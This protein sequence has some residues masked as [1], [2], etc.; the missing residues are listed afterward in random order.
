MSDT[1]RIS[2]LEG[3]IADL[4]RQLGEM[5]RQLSEAELDQW[6]GR[7]DDLEVQVHL[8]TLDV[9]DRL[10]PLIED[11][12]N[13]WLDAREQLSGSTETASDV[14]TTLRKGLEQA[15]GEIR[16]AVLEAR[17]TARK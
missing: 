17:E 5:R 15:M 7:I 14:V 2:S 13:A 6:R 3:Q 16:A 11:L 12:R 1:D 8:G 10:S 9:R 4:E